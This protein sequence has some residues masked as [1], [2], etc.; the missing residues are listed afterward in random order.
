MTFTTEVSLGTLIT[1]ATFLIALS[2]F[3]WSNVKRIAQDGKRWAK[4][5]MKVNLMYKYFRKT[6]LGLNGGDEDH[7][8]HEDS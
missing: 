3:H 6:A 2:S 8:D 4:M 5:E 1:V 7:E